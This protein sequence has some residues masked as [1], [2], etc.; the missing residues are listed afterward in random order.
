[1]SAT[2]FDPSASATGIAILSP[3]RPGETEINAAFPGGGYDPMTGQPYPRGVYIPG[4]GPPL[5]YNTG[6]PRAVGGNPEVAGVAAGGRPLY[7]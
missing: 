7:L 5:D 6:I 2:G 4:F 3:E 1:V